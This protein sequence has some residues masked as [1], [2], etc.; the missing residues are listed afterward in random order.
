[1][2][3]YTKPVMDVIELERIDV[4]TASCDRC[5][6]TTWNGQTFGD[7]GDPYHELGDGCIVPGCGYEHRD[8]PEPE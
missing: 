7:S 8:R 2:K 3:K 4:L 1:M 5:S 6:S